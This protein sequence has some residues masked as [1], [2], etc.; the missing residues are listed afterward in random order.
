MEL[1]LNNQ[2]WLICHKTKANETKPIPYVA[3]SKSCR[4]HSV[5][6]GVFARSTVSIILSA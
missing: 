1:A 3:I 2:Q 6:A 4:R 5:C